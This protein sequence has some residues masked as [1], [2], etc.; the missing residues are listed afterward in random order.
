MEK[1]ATLPP[2]PEWVTS[3]AKPVQ[4]LD[5]L[6]LR[7]PVERLGLTLLAAVTTISPTL[8]YIG[9]RAWIARQ[10]ALATLPDDWDSFQPYAAKVEAA[11]A[12][13][14]LLHNRQA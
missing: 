10:Y 2:P 3:D 5:L 6:G 4:G 11:I 14:N 9:L 13:G 1:L 7:V 12:I 8:R